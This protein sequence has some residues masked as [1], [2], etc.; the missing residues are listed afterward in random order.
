MKFNFAHHLILYNHNY[1][2]FISNFEYIHIYSKD[3][4]HNYRGRD[5]GDQSQAIKNLQNPYSI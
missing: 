4:W 3:Q 1:K 2:N 5:Q